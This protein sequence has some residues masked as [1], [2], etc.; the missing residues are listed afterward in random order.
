MD[1]RT[2]RIRALNDRLRTTGEGGNVVI[3]RGLAALDAEFS[4]K[5][6]P[7]FSASTSSPPTTTRTVSTIAPSLKWP[8]SA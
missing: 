7:P 5:S 3:T 4:R 2:E 1:T 8:V 6:S